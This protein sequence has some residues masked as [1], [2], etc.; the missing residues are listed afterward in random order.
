MVNRISHIVRWFLLWFDILGEEPTNSWY[1]GNRYYNF[2]RGGFS[3]ETGSFTQVV[4][5]NSKTLGAGIAFTENGRSAYIVAL[6]TPPGNFGNDY[7][8]NV[9]PDQC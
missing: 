4:W 8:N 6:Y 1:N 2:R 3:T 9:F 5:K 7:Q